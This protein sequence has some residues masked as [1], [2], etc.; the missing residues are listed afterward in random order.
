MNASDMTALLEASYK[1]RPL[2]AAGDA[3]LRQ[4]ILDTAPHFPADVLEDFP[5]WPADVLGLASLEE[6]N[7]HGTGKSVAAAE[8]VGGIRRDSI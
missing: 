5:S 3:G 1:L 8:Q 7:R 4:Q 2:W 6:G